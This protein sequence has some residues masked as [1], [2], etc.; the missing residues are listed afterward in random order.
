MALKTI[1]YWHEIFEI[2]FFSFHV[3]NKGQIKSYMGVLL[4]HTKVMNFLAISLKLGISNCTISIK[5]Q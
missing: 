4:M 5:V 3:Y 2:V 1:S